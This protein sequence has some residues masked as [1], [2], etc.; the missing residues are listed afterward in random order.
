MSASILLVEDDAEIGELIRRYL[1]SN[2]MRAE[3]VA[4]GVEMDAAL[5][6]RRH[7]LII[8]DVNL[9]D[10]DGLSIC[11]RLRAAGNIP[12]VMVTAQ[13]EDAD[14]IAGLET[15]ADDYIAKPFNPRELLARLRTVLR[16]TNGA[17]EVGASFARQVYHFDGWRIDVSSRTVTAPSGVKV[18]MTGAEFDLLHALCEHPNRILTRDQLLSLTH[19][20]V[21]GPCERSI[22]TLVSRL[23]QKV[24]VDAK[25]PKL[26]Q[27]VRSEGYV[28]ATQVIR[29]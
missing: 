1:E 3:L 17:Q 24:E 15:G 18:S 16:R 9:P 26:I 10:E 8:L 14:K 7:D 11:R 28:F 12:I 25:N 29:R 20:P 13:T 22:D 4:N 23:R 27:T 19:G 2:Q 6:A 21:T 5:A